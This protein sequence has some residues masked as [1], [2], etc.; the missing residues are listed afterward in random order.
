MFEQRKLGMRFWIIWFIVLTFSGNEK[1]SISHLFLVPF[2][3]FSP[4]YMWKI[5]N[6]SACLSVQ[7]VPTLLLVIWF[8]KWFLRIRIWSIGI[9]THQLLTA[10]NSNEQLSVTEKLRFFCLTS[11][12]MLIMTSSNKLSWA[13]ANLYLY[14]FFCL[15]Y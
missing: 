5:M 9:M 1:Q 10:C 6:M 12:K 11:V 13:P 7:H 2:V 3:S 14:L 8:H 15:Y 4:V